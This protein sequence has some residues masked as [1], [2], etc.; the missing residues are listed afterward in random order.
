MLEA[1]GK[2]W[3]LQVAPTLMPALADSAM[4]MLVPQ[5]L[6]RKESKEPVEEHQTF[7]VRDGE[8]AHLWRRAQHDCCRQVV[9]GRAGSIG[10]SNQ[11]RLHPG[12]YTVDPDHV[13]RDAAL[14]KREVQAMRNF[15][16]HR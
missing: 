9:E 3:Y 1:R 4:Q 15:L 14:Q 16:G 7:V 12:Q 10:S 5:H 8:V 11:T 13:R 2:L 6:H